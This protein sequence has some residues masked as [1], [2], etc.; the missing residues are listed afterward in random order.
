[1]AWKLRCPYCYYFGKN[2]PSGFGKISSKIFKK[3]ES[4]EFTNSKNVIP[5]A[6]ISVVVMFAP[7]ILSI[8]DLVDEF[9]VPLLI[10]LIIYII[11]SIPISG[12]IR[13]R[14]CA[15]CKQGELG[16]PANRRNQQN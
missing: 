2:C 14:D 8:I 11:I 16:C 13:Q 5:V 6:F 9:S 12:K 4:L 1:M 10:L 15:H 3:G 7:I